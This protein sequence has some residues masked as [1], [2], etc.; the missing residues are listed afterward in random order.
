MAP[1]SSSIT[2]NDAFFRPIAELAQ[3]FPHTARAKRYP[4]ISGSGPVSSGSWRSRPVA[5][6][7]C[8]NTAPA[9]E[10]TPKLSNY[11]S[12]LHSPCCGEVLQDV[13]EAILGLIMASYTDRLAASPNS[14]A[15]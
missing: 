6:P 13:V 2:V 1:N 9:W 7:F 4:T 12:C 15:S 14:T 11:F 8:S 5:A 10:D 3:A